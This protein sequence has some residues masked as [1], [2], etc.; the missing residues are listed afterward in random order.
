[1]SGMVGLEVVF[2]RDGVEGI[3]AEAKGWDISSYELKQAV[4][5]TDRQYWVMS[6]G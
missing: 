5:S 3:L 1:M 6:S 4:Y 2:V